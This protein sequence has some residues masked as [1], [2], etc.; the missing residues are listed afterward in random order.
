MARCMGFATMAACPTPDQ[1]HDHRL[2]TIAP[3]ERVIVRVQTA[4]LSIDEVAG[5]VADSAAGAVCIF[6]GTVR[7]SSDAGDVTGLTYEA[8]HELAEQ[9]LRALGE[10]ILE[11]WPAQ[12]VAIVHRVGELAVGETSVIVAVSSPHRAEAFDA[13][14]HG[15]EALKHDVPI[16]KKEALVS[17][18]AHWVMGS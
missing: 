7:G 4:P 13:C 9:R 3:T 12:K 6:T 1:P 17:G 18:D 14:R 8:W 16:W 10:E 11:R 2:T 5:A 15:I